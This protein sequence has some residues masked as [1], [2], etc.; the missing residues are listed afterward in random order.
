MTTGDVRVVFMGTPDFAVPSLRA[1]MRRGY[2]VVAVYTQPDRP[3]GRGHKLVASPVKVAAEEFGLEVCQPERLQR[4]EATARLQSLAPDLIIVAAYGQ[5]LRPAIIDLPRFGCLN[6]HASLLPR[7]RGASAIASAILAGDAATGISIMLI[8]SGMD[9]G[10]VL[11]SRATAIQ[12]EDTTG[13]LTNRLALLGADLL[14]DTVPGWLSGL[15]VPEPQDDRLATLAPL[16]TKQQGEIDWTK[17][18]VQLWREVRAFN[19]WP[20]STTTLSGEKVQV[21]EAAVVSSN[22]AVDERQPGDIIDADIVT[23]ALSQEMRRR[24]GFGVI[25]GDGILIP[26]TVRRAGRNAVSGAEFRRGIHGLPEL[27]FGRPRA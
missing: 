22:G 21:I 3:S 13:S 26:L 4:S 24:A 16:F 8:D 27:R 1:L 11:S 12:D 6:V 17:S 9:T 2:A 18:A 5:I 20:L 10:P 14:V 25:T 19:P 23:P 7:H 15:V